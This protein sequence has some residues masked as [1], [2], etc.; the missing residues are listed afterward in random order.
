[1]CIN[2]REKN[3]NFKFDENSY[4]YADNYSPLGRSDHSLLKFYFHC[5]IQQENIDRVKYY[6]DKANFLPMKEDLS[7]INWNDELDDMNVN[8]L[9]NGRYLKIDC[10]KSKASMYRSVNPDR[11]KI[12]KVKL[13]LISKHLK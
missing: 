1:M 2:S 3:T 8:E 11:H 7:A 12:K 9:G 13:I 5:Y 4:K 10:M 6:Y